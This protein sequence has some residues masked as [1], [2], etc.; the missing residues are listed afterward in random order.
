H[1]RRAIG[2]SPRITFT[3]RPRTG[4]PSKC[5]APLAGGKGAYR[6]STNSDSPTHTVGVNGL[7][8]ALAIVLGGLCVIGLLSAVTYRARTRAVSNVRPAIVEADHTPKETVPTNEQNERAAAEAMWI[9]F[10]ASLKDA[11]SIVSMETLDAATSAL[12]AN[13]G[14]ERVV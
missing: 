7:Y 14:N 3:G 2:E 1:C 13:T 6:M 11:G 10:A 12:C 4:H 9:L 5:H 8:R